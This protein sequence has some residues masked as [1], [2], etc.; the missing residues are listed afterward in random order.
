MYKK[1][2]RKCKFVVLLNKPIAFLTFSLQSL[3][4]KLP[5][6]GRLTSDALTVLD[7]TVGAFK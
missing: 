4:L 3:L 6:Y 1:S 5:I 7:V 2:C